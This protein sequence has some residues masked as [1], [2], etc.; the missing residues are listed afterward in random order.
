MKVRGLALAA[1][2]AGL[3]LAG[4]AARPPRPAPL[5]AGGYT[6]LAGDFHVHGFPDGLPPWDSA[7]EARRR[8]LDVIALTSHNAMRGWWMWTHA[9]WA[10]GDPGDPIVLPG[11]E[12]TGVGY[13]MAIVGLTQTVAWHQPLP[14]AVA[15][16]HAQGAVAIL[17]H[18]V[19]ERVRRT[20]DDDDLR[21]IDGIEA[22]HPQMELGESARRELA[23][24]YARAVSV[25]PAIAAIGS[26]DFHYASPI[27]LCRTYLFVRE[28]TA[29]GVLDALRAGRTVAC[30]AHGRTYGPAALTSIVASRCAGDAAAAPLGDT[31]ASRAGAWLAWAGLVALVLAG[32][33]RS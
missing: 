25:N 27:G 11:E 3:A 21:R 23:R 8:R 10:A 29:A 15:A 16:A 5:T 19:G 17:A 30:D 20:I 6:V 4:T 2:T 12:L 24:M 9:P 28:P 31:S 7:R 1:V 14:A 32:A 26:S 33:S 13:H 18:P 22:A